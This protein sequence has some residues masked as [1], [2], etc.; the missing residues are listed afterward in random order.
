MEFLLQ[1]SVYGTG[2]AETLL[3]LLD[4]MWIKNHSSSKGIIYI[5]SGFANYNGGV[6]FYPH[7]T[8]HVHE[9]GRIKVIIS[10]NTS[11]KLSSIQVVEALLQCG[12]EVYIVNRKRLLHAKCYGYKTDVEEELIVS[13][14]NFTG[15]GMSQNGEAA[16]KIDTR[17]VRDMGFSWDEF[18]DSMFKQNWNIYQLEANDIKRKSNPGWSLLYD[19]IHQIGKLDES[20]QMTMVITL[21]HSDTAR[22]QADPGTNAGKGTQY[23]WLSKGTFDFF[24]ALTIKNQRGVKNTYSC[25]IN[26]N[27]VDLDIQEESRVTFEADNNLDFRLG[28]AALRYTKIADE[29]DIALISRVAEYDYELRIVKKEAAMYN[30]MLKY[31][32]SFIGNYGKRF[33]YIGN[34][35]MKDILE[36]ETE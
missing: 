6:R 24:P 32:T 23:F 35:D 14:G 34:D 31:A 10:G 13:S 22:I 15:P 29:N 20:Q 8:Q 5:V 21:N 2:N 9:G 1:P 11:Q 16:V 27:Y 3:K 25:N 33:G 7:F 4:N 36:E 30:R 26:L 18:W 19:E 17:Y 28:T 12:A